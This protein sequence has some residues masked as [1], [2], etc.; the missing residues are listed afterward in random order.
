[1][2]SWSILEYGKQMA[3]SGELSHAM[4]VVKWDIVYLLKFISKLVFF[5]ERCYV[6]D[7][8]YL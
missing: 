3:A 2:L 4:N 6:V 5:T 8:F 1:M 7:F